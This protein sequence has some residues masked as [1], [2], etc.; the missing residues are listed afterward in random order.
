MT[1]ETFHRP[2][3][4]LA[5]LLALAAPEAR[6][7]A[8][9]T[10]AEGFTPRYIDAAARRSNPV[11]IR[12]WPGLTRL[13]TWT[14]TIEAAVAEQDS[15]VSTDLV[16]AFRARV[17]SLA[18][19]PVPEFLAGRRDTLAATF[20]AIG[21]RIDAAEAALAAT[22][23]EVRATGE[24]GENVPERQRTL[25]TGRTAVTVPAGV[26]VG[27]RDTLPKAAIEGGEPA[28][29]FDHLSLALAGLDGLVHL[30]RAADPAVSGSRS[31]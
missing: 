25:V 29:Y 1:P 21:A 12:D 22:A 18:A 28:N 31:P 26:A 3:L 24:A 9:S 4:F 17:D 15:T 10:A 2:I 20:E 13:L 30:V 7:Q 27:D 16:E 11:M 5:L 8:D 14:R 6:G 23:P 19:E